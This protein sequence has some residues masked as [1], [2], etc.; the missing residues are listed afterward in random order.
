[1]DGKET[2]LDDQ[3]EADFAEFIRSKVQIGQKLEINFDQ[4]LGIGGE[5]LVLRRFHGR[6]HKAFKIIPLEDE[7]DKTKNLILD[8]QRKMNLSNIEIENDYESSSLDDLRENECKLL[9]DVNYNQM[10]HQGL[11]LRSNLEVRGEAEM[12]EDELIEY[13]G[14]QKT[15]IP[16]DWENY[17]SEIFDEIGKKSEILS[18]R[19]EYECSAVRHDNIINYENVTLD[20]VDGHACLIAGKLRFE[21]I[22]NSY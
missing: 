2:F 12:Y 3:S 1:M 18:G 17:D 13:G 4:L 14:F 19:S 21:M 11:E 16:D 7:S 15:E 5:S 6:D 9:P 10:Y 20:F 8:F 22:Q